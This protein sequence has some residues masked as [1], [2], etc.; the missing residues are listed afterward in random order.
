MEYNDEY[1][2]CGRTY[3]TVRIFGLPATE[4]GSALGIV[5]TQTQSARVAPPKRPDG[6]FLTTEGTIPSRDIR[7][8][9]DWLLD[10]LE[11]KAGTLAELRSRGAS[12]DVVCYWLSANGHGGPILSP[13][14]S[15]RLAALDLECGFDVY[16][17]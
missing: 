13:S 5:A 9:L 10:R 15:K 7:R 11:P 17:P 8:H 3:A 12:V 14:Q 6:W 4:V 2:T 16:F 1:A